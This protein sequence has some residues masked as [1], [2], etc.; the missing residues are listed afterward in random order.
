M[1]FNVS[2]RVQVR[3]ESIKIRNSIKKEKVDE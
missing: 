3:R 1:P 2:E